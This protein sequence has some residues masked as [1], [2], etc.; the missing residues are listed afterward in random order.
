MDVR[1][2]GVV[3]AFDTFR[4]IPTTSRSVALRPQLQFVYGQTMWMA[5][6]LIFL[7]LFESMN[8]DL[9]LMLSAVG[10]FIIMELTDPFAADPTLRLRLRWLA[11]I[12][13]I[14]IGY[15]LLER[16]VEVLAEQLV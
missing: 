13:L 3:T 4:P 9:F 5:A 2:N 16:L 11:I 12:G 7:V 10:F 1:I 8:L 15:I 14:I 6:L